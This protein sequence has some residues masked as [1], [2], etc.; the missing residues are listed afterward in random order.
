MIFLYRIRT[1]VLLVLQDIDAANAR[2][3]GFDIAEGRVAFFDHDGCSLNPLYPNL[4]GEYGVVMSYGRFRLERNEGAEGLTGILRQV[5]VVDGPPGLSTPAEVSVHLA[6]QTGANTPL[7]CPPVA[8]H[9]LGR[10]DGGRRL[11]QSL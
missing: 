9:S 2:C 3:D 11:Q 1:H 6:S 5:L 8:M 7:A 4:A 10:I